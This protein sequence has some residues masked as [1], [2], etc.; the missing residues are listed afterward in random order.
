MFQGGFRPET[1][2]LSCFAADSNIVFDTHHDY[3]AGRPTTSDNL[4]TFMCED[5][6][7]SI[8]DGKFPVFVGEWSIQAVSNN[9]FASRAN[10]LNN[11]LN[12]WFK[13]TQGSS[14]WTAKF[15]GNAPVGGQGTQSDYWD[16]LTFIDMKAINARSSAGFCP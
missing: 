11:G 13:Y 2:W 9:I 10:N 15:S 5:A 12:A 3:F 7:D 14:Y 4:P 1:F 6:K 8:G 16:Y